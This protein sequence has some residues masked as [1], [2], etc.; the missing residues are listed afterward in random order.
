MIFP[1]HP[2]DLAYLHSG[3]S[4]DLLVEIEKRPAHRSRRG[5]SNRRFADARQPH[6][7]Q[8]RHAP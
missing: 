5:L 1:L 2:E 3:A 4:L 6:E 8:V 7:N